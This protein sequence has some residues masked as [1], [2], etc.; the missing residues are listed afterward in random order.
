ML[1]SSIMLYELCSY[2][3]SNGNSNGLIY[4]NH[5][6]NHATSD[7]G[8]EHRSFA[9]VRGGGLWE[10]LVADKWHGQSNLV[11]FSD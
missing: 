4:C 9:G 11:L 2:G 1:S 3:N 8:Y 7:P 10:R 5:S 6:G